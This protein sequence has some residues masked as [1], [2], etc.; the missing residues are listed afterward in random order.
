MHSCSY[1]QAD[2]SKKQT[3]YFVAIMRSFEHLCF[4]RTLDKK[5]GTFEFFVPSGLVPFFL[6]VMSF[7]EQQG[8]ISNF[9]ELPNRLVQP[10]N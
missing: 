10:K 7:M 8:I 2:I 9:K 6:E 1:Y 4:D 3:W 5:T